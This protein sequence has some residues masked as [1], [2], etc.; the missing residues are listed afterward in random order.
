MNSVY[1]LNKNGIWID[2]LCKES[3]IRDPF[4]VMYAHACHPAAC[5]FKKI[6]QDF[7][8]KV[9]QNTG[10]NKISDWKQSQKPKPREINMD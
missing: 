7:L 2:K 9:Q 3:T 5:V 6:K 10:K 1:D 4:S 8:L